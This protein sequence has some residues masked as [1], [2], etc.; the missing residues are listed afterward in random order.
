MSEELRQPQVVDLEALLQP[1]SEESPSGESLRYSGVYDQIAEARRADDVLNRGDWQT[2]LKTADYRAVVDLAIPAL[3]ARTKDLQIGVWLAEAL[4]KQYGF[5]GLRDSLQL[6]VGL[7]E[8]FWETVHPEIDEG[9]MDGR[10]NA[11]SWF[12]TNGSLV[13]KEGK[14]TGYEGYSFLDWE[15]SKV[16]DIPENL[17]TYSTEDQ[18]RYNQLKAQAEKEQRV[19]ADM[20]RKEKAATRR[21]FCEQVNFTIEECWT[22]L[23]DLNRVI[24]EKYE[25]KKITR[26][27]TRPG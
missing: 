24:E 22:A 7:H 11:I 5:V 13:V 8:K 27:G 9:D 16:F 10:A 4:M 2:E 17:D 12:D 1:I 26:C 23:N 19:T 20:W 18:V 14:I 21:A 15:D 3:T 6:L 25:P